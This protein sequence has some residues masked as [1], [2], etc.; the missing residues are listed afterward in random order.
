MLRNGVGPCAEPARERRSEARSFQWVALQDA[1][2]VIIWFTGL[3][4]DRTG[5]GELSN[6]VQQ[7]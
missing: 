2:L 6:I 7:R 1:P 5:D 3:V 4:Q